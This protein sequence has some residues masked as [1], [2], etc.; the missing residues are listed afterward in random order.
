MRCPKAAGARRSSSG[1]G[2]FLVLL[3]EAV[4][5]F[6][7]WFSYPFWG[8][9]FLA[10]LRLGIASLL[11]SRPLAWGFLKGHHNDLFETR[12]FSPVRVAELL[13]SGELDAGLV[14]VTELLVDGGLRV[15]PDL[16][17]ATRGVADTALVQLKCPPENA[18]RIAVDR[19]SRTTPILAQVVFAALYG[20]HPEL[21]PMQK[22]VKIPE[23]C[24]GAILLSEEA[25]QG[26]LGL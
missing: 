20:T 13:R 1:L 22:V 24:D 17:L 14:P 7:G 8:I 6:T 11:D 3:A 16:C 19:S 4:R 10:K 15:I 26:G 18:T 2:S 23:D 9:S 12:L 25:S 21:V 5:G